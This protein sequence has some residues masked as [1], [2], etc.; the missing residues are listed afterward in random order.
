MDMLSEISTPSAENRAIEMLVLDAAEAGTIRDLATAAEAEY[1][2]VDNPRFLSE[3]ALIAHEL[4]RSVRR[5]LVKARVSDRVHASVLRGLL[6]DHRALEPTPQRWNDADTPGSRNCAF[7]IMICAA[8]LGDAIGWAAQQAGRLVSDVV[9]TPGQEHGLVSSSSC[10]E[11]SWHTEDAFS[12][13]R[14][15]YVGL[16]CLRNPIRTPTTISYLDS[17]AME[18]ALLA[19]LREPRFLTV[20]DPSHVR[21]AGQGTRAADEPV[22]VLSGAPAAPVLRV[23]RDFTRAPHGDI[24]ASRALAALVAHLDAN[25]YPLALEPGDMCFLDNRTVVHGRERFTPRYDGTDRWLKRVGVVVDLRRT[26]PERGGE[27]T[28]VIGATA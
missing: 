10:A 16:Y 18:P 17:G 1:H 2:A 9:P 13:S 24:E 23:D 6:I 19:V 20:P 28:R 12:P 27:T 11:L 14:A 26:R 4:P 25:V 7:Q 5:L 22:A 8:L 15:D 21:Q 3:V